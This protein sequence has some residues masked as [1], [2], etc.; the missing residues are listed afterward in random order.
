MSDV[1]VGGRIGILMC[2]D[3]M[4]ARATSKK[5]FLQ[6]V[7]VKKC[8]KTQCNRQSNIR[9]DGQRTDGPHFT[10][11]NLPPRRRGPRDPQDALL[12]LLSFN[13]GTALGFP[14]L[15]EIDSWRE[16]FCV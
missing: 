1:G 4:P 7:E 2:L 12:G 8:F 5:A 15:M 9:H 11:I 14:S 13:L 6:E 3:Q 16:V 10:I